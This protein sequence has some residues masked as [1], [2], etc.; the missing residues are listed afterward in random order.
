MKQIFNKIKIFLLVSVL[1]FSVFLQAGITYAV[2]GEGDATAAALQ[3]SELL[4]PE[5]LDPYYY[6]HWFRW[7]SFNPMA[8][9][10]ELTRWE[11]I[12]RA[13]ALDTRTPIP[14]HVSKYSF[15]DEGSNELWAEMKEI[16]GNKGRVWSLFKSPVASVWSGHATASAWNRI[17]GITRPEGLSNEELTARMRQKWLSE[18]ASGREGAITE[19]LQTPDL[20]TQGKWKALDAVNNDQILA[21]FKNSDHIV[22]RATRGTMELSDLIAIR[23]LVKFGLNAGYSAAEWTYWIQGF[24]IKSGLKL[25]RAVTYPVSAR[26]AEAIHTPFELSNT[27]NRKVITTLIGHDMH[28]PGEY[29]RWQYEGF[30]FGKGPLDRMFWGMN[31]ADPVR[32]NPDKGEWF[33]MVRPENVTKVTRTMEDGSKV[34]EYTLSTA[35][36]ANFKQF[37]RRGPAE[38]TSEKIIPDVNEFG[39][40]PENSS[41][42]THTDSGRMWAKFADNNGSTRDKLKFTRV[43]TPEEVAALYEEREGTFFVDGVISRTKSWIRRAHTARIRGA[44]FNPDFKIGDFDVGEFLGLPKLFHFPTL[45]HVKSSKSL[46]Q[47][48]GELEPRWRVSV[49]GAEINN[50]LLPPKAM[51]DIRKALAKG[52]YVENSGKWLTKWEKTPHNYS[53]ETIFAYLKTAALK[54]TASKPEQRELARMIAKREGIK[55]MGLPENNARFFMNKGMVNAD[56]ESMQHQVE[57]TE[58]AIA[59]HH[60]VDFYHNKGLINGFVKRRNEGI[61]EED[62]P[63][64]FIL[65]EGGRE[66]KVIVPRSADEANLLREKMPDAKVVTRDT[67]GRS[68]V[69]DN[70]TGFDEES[71][72]KAG[73]SE[74]DGIEMDARP[75]DGANKTEAYTEILD[76]PE[77]YQET[78]AAKQGL[79]AAERAG[80]RLVTAAS[81]RVEESAIKLS[82]A[83]ETKA[84]ESAVRLEETLGENVIKAAAKAG[85]RVAIRGVGNALAVTSTVLA[86]VPFIGWAIDSAVLAGTMVPPPPTSG[87]AI[88][89]QVYITSQNMTS[90]GFK[91]DRKISHCNTGEI[92]LEKIK[93]SKRKELDAYDIVPGVGPERPV[94]NIKSSDLGQINVKLRGKNDHGAECVIAFREIKK[95]NSRKNF[96]GLVPPSYIMFRVQ[97]NWSGYNGGAITVNQL[98]ADSGNA[99]SDVKVKINAIRGRATIKNPINALESM[100]PY[101]MVST[102]KAH[103][104]VEN[105]NTQSVMIKQNLKSGEPG[106]VN[107]IISPKDDSAADSLTTP[108]DSLTLPAE[109]LTQK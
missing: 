101:Y 84:E 13:N 60:T 43:E 8:P 66:T 18:L 62:A 55:K 72:F 32:F 37:F 75:L 82:T 68:R 36:W 20:F 3:R 14:G 42:W 88:S 4:F 31:T 17:Q 10:D 96:M 74:L 15:M 27:L 16:W 63:T 26:V 58:H 44:K 95:V 40:V 5:M 94:I 38:V 45:A 98:G 7:E 34:T 61:G 11:R 47:L 81:V 30:R 21:W 102:M 41:W 6:G 24:I 39:H 69:T 106:Q 83:M 67:E 85:A 35:P 12:W 103:N 79:S 46:P 97:Q 109:K 80:E 57:I 33:G 65:K 29:V 89:N 19:R 77:F 23:P 64:E 78:L 87:A 56:S 28:D 71:S 86:A 73:N 53:D 76:D 107:I 49:D 99:P 9:Q 70:A 2:L 93:G 51:E 1:G 90:V 54:G 100:D 25:A 59:E 22:A 104:N 48:H 105:Q 50:M 108:A 52:E 91:F 92:K